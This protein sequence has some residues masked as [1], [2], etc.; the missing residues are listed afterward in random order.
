[1]S[2]TVILIALAEQRGTGALSQ[3]PFTVQSDN[4][5]AYFR[6]NETTGSTT[7]T[8]IVGSRIGSV[9]TGTTLGTA[10]GPLTFGGDT[11]A[12][13]DGSSGKIDVAFD[14]TL[15]TTNF[16]IE[17]WARVTGGAGNY[18]SPVTSRTTTPGGYLFYASNLND[19]EYWTGGAWTVI[20]GGP[21][22]NNAWTHLVG[23]YDGTNMRFYIN[24]SQV[25]SPT[26]STY[27]LNT[28]YPFRIG[29]GATEGGGTFFFNGDVAEV[30]YYNT[31]L[32]ADRILAHFEAASQEFF[33]IPEP[34]TITLLGLGLA[35]LIVRQRRRRA[36]VR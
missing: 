36:A 13:F 24:G 19:W 7:V 27:N 14:A 3:Y 8:D 18:R 32:S 33:I 35:G 21:V 6:L 25:G 10:P 17:A 20:N 31:A 28:T 2:L 22:T 30:A 12:T 5:V 26:A 23:T 34:S 9:F 4:P 1:V 15:N 11:A 29:A 16:T